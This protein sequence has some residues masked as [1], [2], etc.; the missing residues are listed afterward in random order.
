MKQI[1]ANSTKVLS[2]AIQ[3]PFKK[4]LNKCNKKF[5]RKIHS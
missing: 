3:K 4:N 5:K 1:K 2:R